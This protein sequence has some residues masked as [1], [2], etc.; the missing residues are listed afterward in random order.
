[1]IRGLRVVAL[2]VVASSAEQRLRAKLAAAQSRTE[3]AM[4]DVS[5][6]SIA[7]AYRCAA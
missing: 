4:R 7:K 2:K 3:L 1:M 5:Q 6:E